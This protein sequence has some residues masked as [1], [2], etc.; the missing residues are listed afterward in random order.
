MVPPPKYV[1]CSWAY[2]C[3]GLPMLSGYLKYLA[4]TSSKVGKGK[5]LSSIENTS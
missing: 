1:G 4:L 5:V 2:D 3:D